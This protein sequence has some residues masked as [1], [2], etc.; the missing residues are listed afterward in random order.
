MRLAHE[1]NKGMEAIVYTDRT[2]ARGKG[3][4]LVQL[5]KGRID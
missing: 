1:T 4:K 5:T 2:E 3:T